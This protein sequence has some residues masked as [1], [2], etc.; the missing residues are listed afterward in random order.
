MIRGDVIFFRNNNSI[1]SKAISYFTKSEFTHVGLIIA[2][3]P[4]TGV[5][6]IIESNRFVNTRISTVQMDDYYHVV[7]TIENRPK[8]V[9]DRILKYANDTVGIKYDYLQIIGMMFSLIVRDTDRRWLFNSKN[10]LICSELI[11]LVYYKAGVKRNNT[12]RLGKVTP[13]ELL[14]VYDFKIRKES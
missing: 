11:D 3:N 4:D 9:L 13:Q 10:K 5:A 8:E 7:Y 6:T 2:F 12:I 1:I 14:Q